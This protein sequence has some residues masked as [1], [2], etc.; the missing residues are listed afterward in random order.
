MVL[1]IATYI[2]EC[3]IQILYVALC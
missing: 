1:L 2:Q 3:K